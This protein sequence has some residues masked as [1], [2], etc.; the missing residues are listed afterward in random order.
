MSEKDAC[1]PSEQAQK[2]LINAS[3]ARREYHLG[4]SKWLRDA[5]TFEELNQL[6]EALRDAD[7]AV[8]HYIRNLE[9]RACIGAELVETIRYAPN[10]IG[11]IQ[12]IAVWDKHHK[13]HPL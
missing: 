10:G 12:T 5:I 8:N 13:E 6:G 3:V 11:A 9:R 2:L 4:H 7:I 1:L